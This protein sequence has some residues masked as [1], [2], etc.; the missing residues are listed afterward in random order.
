MILARVEQSAVI[1][2]IPTNFKKQTFSASN[3]VPAFF[4]IKA[5]SSY[6]YFSPM[7]CHVTA[8][9]FLVQNLV[10][11]LCYFTLSEN[12]MFAQDMLKLI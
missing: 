3:R 12:I 10:Q 1:S 2:A 7:L 6:G 4:A 11:I 5:F 9:L 8:I